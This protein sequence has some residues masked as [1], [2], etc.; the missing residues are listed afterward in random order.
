MA[1]PRRAKFTFLGHA[2]VRCDLPDGR[3]LAIDPWLTGNPS[4]PKGAGFERLDL[5]LVTHAHD[6]HA[7]DVVRLAQRH[8]ALVV[9]VF[10]L[11]GWFASQGVARTS[12]MNLGGTQEVD[13]IRIT[14]VR[15]DHS[16]S[17]TDGEGRIVYGGVAC[18]YVVHLPDGCTFY[19][20]GDTALFSDMSLVGDLWRPE[21]AFLPIGGHFT[22]DPEQ[23]ARACRLVHAQWVIPIHYGT[24]PL[25]AGTP[26]DL[27]RALHDHG[28]PTQ[29]VALA[30]GESWSPPD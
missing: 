1:E 29:V 24:F 20:S 23:A 11:C 22:M 3:T 2:A 13:G 5:V 16:S 26:A 9:G 19:H 17:L 14:Q 25:L 18:G 6:D 8:D 28:T 15:A 21:I 7:A 10:D 12:G 30:P 4:A 27:A